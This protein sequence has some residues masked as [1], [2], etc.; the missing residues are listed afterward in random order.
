MQTTLRCLLKIREALNE[1]YNV[2]CGDQI[3]LNEM[4]AFLREI[5]GKDINAVYNS[6]RPGML[7]TQKPTLARFQKNLDINHNCYL[8]KA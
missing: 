2:A 1:V 6:E 3:T 4:V 7:N 8:R 5:S